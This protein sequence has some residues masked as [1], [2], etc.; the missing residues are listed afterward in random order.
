MGLF[1]CCPDVS[2]VFLERRLP[3]EHASL[4][5]DR[6]SGTTITGILS[7]RFLDW[8]EVA[9]RTVSDVTLPLLI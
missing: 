4:N 2:E 6:R 8:L 5:E 1:A 3:I 9:P 7:R